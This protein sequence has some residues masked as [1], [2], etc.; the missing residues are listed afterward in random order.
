MLDYVKENNDAVFD[1]EI[2][3]KMFNRNQGESGGFEAEPSA[4]V[5]DPLMKDALRNFIK[6]NN[7]SVSKLQRIFNIGFN[8]AGR[9]VDQMEHAGFVSPKDSK[10]NRVIFITQQE[11]EERFGQ[12]L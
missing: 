4:E 10:N 12:D 5:F 2:E 11:F 9:I 3:D 8:R 1:S 7:A 6:T